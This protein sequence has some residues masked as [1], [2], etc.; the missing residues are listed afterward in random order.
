[1]HQF[2]VPLTAPLDDGYRHE[3]DRRLFFVSEQ[4]GSYRVVRE[5]GKICGV[6]VST[7]DAERELDI[8]RKI[9][10][11]ID[12]EVSCQRPAAPRVL[13]RSAGSGRRI[14]PVYDELVRNELVFEAGEGQVALAEPLISLMDRIDALFRNHALSLPSAQEFRYPTLIPSRVLRECGSLESFPHMTMFVTRLHSDI[15]VYRE[16]GNRLAAGRPLQELVFA[17][18]GNADYSLPLTMCF[19]TYHQLRDTHQPVNRVITSR[20]KSF[21]FESRYHRTMERLWDYTTREI[22]FLG[23]PEFVQ[24][25]RRR[26]FD[27]VRAIVERLGLVARCEVANDPFF[28]TPNIAAR[29]VNQR[30]FELKYELQMNVAEERSISVASFNFHDEFFGRRFGITRGSGVP[31]VTGCVGAGLERFA[32]AFVCQHGTDPAAWP[33]IEPSES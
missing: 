6:E 18:C 17:H 19:H 3:L 14:E 24:E 7:P 29:V 15:D 22:V 11:T 25:C 27:A 10:F 12:S 4:I 32:Y 5:Q 26:T 8:R 20:G 31:I 13:W 33:P 9:L 2:F 28:A 23:D 1:M 16:F 30:I 21:R